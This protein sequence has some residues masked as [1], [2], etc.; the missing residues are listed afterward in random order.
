[1]GLI[2]FHVVFLD[3]LHIWSKCGEY[4]GLLR[5]IL[6]VPQNKRVYLNDVVLHLVNLSC[7][8]SGLSFKG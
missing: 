7:C 3:I 1:M 2:I 4:Q 8:Q 6:S 5:E